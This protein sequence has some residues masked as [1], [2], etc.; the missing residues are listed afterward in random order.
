MGYHHVV[1]SASVARLP[2]E[3]VNSRR[4]ATP[5]I[6]R[7]TLMSSPRWGHDLTS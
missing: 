7:T 6:R 2:H 1:D 3:V 5:E 4:T